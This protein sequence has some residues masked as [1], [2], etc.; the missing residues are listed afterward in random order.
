[1][2]PTVWVKD[3]AGLVPSSRILAEPQRLQVLNASQEDAGLYSYQQRLTQR[4]LCHFSARLT[5]ECP[6]GGRGLRHLKDG[7]RGAWGSSEAE[8]QCPLCSPVPQTLLPPETMKTRRMRLKT[9]VSA[10][11]A[12]RAREGKCV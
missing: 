1:M 10:V 8:G 2:G 3:G 9:Q 4:V 11:P 7:W 6:R 12:G 5:G